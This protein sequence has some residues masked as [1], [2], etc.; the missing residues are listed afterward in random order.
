MPKRPTSLGGPLKVALLQTRFRI[1]LGHSESNRTDRAGPH[2][3]L[4]VAPRA[5]LP[6]ALLRV[7]RVVSTRI[8]SH[9]RT[10]TSL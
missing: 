8:L 7:G 3:R 2:L 6:T 1:R 4:A 9:R 5:S 10:A